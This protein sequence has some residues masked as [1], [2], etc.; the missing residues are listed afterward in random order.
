MIDLKLTIEKVP[1]ENLMWGQININDNLL[2]EKSD[3]E[4]KL[5]AKMKI[6]LSQWEG[7]EE[8]NYTLTKQYI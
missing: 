7:L 1:N 8:G 5:L 4:I 3:S 6:L 2:I